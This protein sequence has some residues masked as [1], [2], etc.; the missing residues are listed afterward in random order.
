MCAL[1]ENTTKNE[2]DFCF[3]N[4]MRII[5][6]FMVSKIVKF[7]FNHSASYK[8]VK[9]LTDAEQSIILK[10]HNG[11]KVSSRSAE[12]PMLNSEN[13]RAAFFFCM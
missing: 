10:R 2:T 5:K 11:K 3:T 12:L 9:I 13:S 4:D 8:K 6:V 7:L 1:P